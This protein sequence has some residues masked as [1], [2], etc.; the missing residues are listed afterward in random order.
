MPL[1]MPQDPPT[2]SESI[3]PLPPGHLKPSALQ[4]IPPADTQL[5]QSAIREEP[6][7]SP[8]E[9]QQ[10]EG[11]L[12]PSGCQ[13]A[14]LSPDSAPLSLFCPMHLWTLTHWTP[15]Q[16]P[17]LPPP[18]THCGQQHQSLCDR[19]NKDMLSELTDQSLNRLISSFALHQLYL[20]Y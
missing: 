19:L 16:V 18:T 10:T 3:S 11:Q 12:H 13:E 20:L 5:L 2:Y 17:P 15:P 1:A 6:A 14:Q 8:A 9:D 7:E 4:V